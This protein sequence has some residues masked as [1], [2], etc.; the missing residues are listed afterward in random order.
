[1]LR[2]ILSRYLVFVGCSAQQT[3]LSVPPSQLCHNT[4]TFMWGSF[5][6]A[7][8]CCVA[9]PSTCAHK[10]LHSFPHKGGN[11]LWQ[12]WFY[13]TPNCTG[14]G[15]LSGLPAASPQEGAP[16]LALGS[17]QPSDSSHGLKSLAFFLF[18]LLLHIFYNFIFSY[19]FESGQICQ[20]VIQASSATR[21]KNCSL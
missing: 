6:L 2:L 11:D 14:T 21:K 8:R 16:L 20:C 10:K 12:C 3:S 1:M 18:F 7:R 19:E 13:R 17:T 4:R 15:C 9:S 5:P